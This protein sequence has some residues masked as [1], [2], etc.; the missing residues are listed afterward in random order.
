MPSALSFASFTSRLTTDLPLA[1]LRREF[2]ARWLLPKKYT[3]P[4]DE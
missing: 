2:E 4:K 3:H 1:N